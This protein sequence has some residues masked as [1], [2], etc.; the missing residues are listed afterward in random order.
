MLDPP[1]PF[2]LTSSLSLDIKIICCPGGTRGYMVHPK[3]SLIFFSVDEYM[4]WIS[5][6]MSG[7]TP[8]T[9]DRFF[10]QMRTPLPWLVV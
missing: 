5:K 4:K 9:P 3:K 6:T 7:R 1:L 2:I 10:A 8:C